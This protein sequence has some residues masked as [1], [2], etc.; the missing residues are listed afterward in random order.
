MPIPIHG[1]S[2]SSGLFQLRLL[3]QEQS[4][5]LGWEDRRGQGFLVHNLLY[6]P[7]FF[8]NCKL[9]SCTA[10]FFFDRAFTFLSSPLQYKSLSM[11]YSMAH[12]LGGTFW[13]SG[14]ETN[15]KHVFATR[16]PSLP[17]T[18]K[19]PPKECKQLHTVETV[20]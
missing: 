20:K 2:Q 18:Q 17:E 3:N 9:L 12:S 10:L 14:S 13:V 11:A 1:H 6:F 16:M 5:F 7:F 4:G 19:A 8:T 15:H